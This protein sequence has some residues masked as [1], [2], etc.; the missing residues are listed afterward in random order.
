MTYNKQMYIY[1]YMY[2]YMC[3]NERRRPSMNC[4]YQT[5]S[6]EGRRPSL[7][8]Q[9]QPHSNEGRRLSFNC[10]IDLNKKKKITPAQPTIDKGHKKTQPAT[11]F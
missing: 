5:Y 2:K 10:K 4:K 1:I 11:W 9:N 8:W 7:E 6:N 3:S